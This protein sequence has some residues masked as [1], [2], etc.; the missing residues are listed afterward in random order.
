[1]FVCRHKACL[2]Q[3]M[4]ARRAIFQSLVLQG[5]ARKY[6]DFF[7][8]CPANFDSLEKFAQKC[9]ATS[10]RA[11]AKLRFPDPSGPLRRF[12]AWIFDNQVEHASRENGR[13]FWFDHSHNV[14]PLRPFERC[15]GGYS[16]DLRRLV[17][18]IRF[19]TRV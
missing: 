12:P 19:Q 3:Q 9:S 5:S 17:V 18:T 8:T 2:R 10:S 6:L 7:L 1:M 11:A 4:A 16:S 15:K 14:S 13:R